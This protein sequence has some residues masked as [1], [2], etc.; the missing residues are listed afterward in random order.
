[1]ST[2]EGSKVSFTEA[3][4]M[5]FESGPGKFPKLGDHL[6]ERRGEVIDLTR[7]MFEG[8]PMWF[9]HQKFFIVTNQ[10]YEGFRRTWK[11]DPGF[12]ARNLIMSE[13]T[14][15]HTDGINEWDPDGPGVD[16]VPLSFYWGEAVCLDMSHVKFKDPDPDG[17]GYATTE[18]IQLA[19][20]ELARNG[21]EIR[22]GD[23]CL[24]WFDCGD[25]LFPQQEFLEQYPGVSWDGAEY[26]ANKGVVNIGTD[27]VGIDNALDVQ[28]SGHMV[29]KKY[30]ITNTE[31]LAHLDKIAN[32]R[33]LFFGL[34]L[35]IEGGT[36]SP[37]RAFAWVPPTA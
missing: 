9:G 4:K 15:T 25:R 7:P 32:K 1:M 3:K 37:I 28:F 20:A 13:H 8:M 18:A 36:G 31:N 23:I 30:G 26:L 5:A 21:E 22:P 11:T 16:G 33:V 17:E 29:C 34:P 19:E 12:Y 35:F 10:D 6:L 27:C 14:G 2:S 24:L